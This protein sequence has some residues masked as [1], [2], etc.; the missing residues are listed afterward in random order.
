M[1]LPI[2]RRTLLRSAVG[3]GLV[4]LAGGLSACTA[5][6]TPAPGTPEVA[7]PAVDP[8]RQLAASARADA[9]RA[10]AVTDAPA[11]ARGALVAVAAERTQHATALDAEVARAAGTVGGTPV[12]APPTTT[13]AP[14]PGSLSQ[15]VAGLQASSAAASAA[16][17]TAASYR[18][19]L[20]GSVAASCAAQVTVL[21]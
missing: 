7:A 19:G 16:A 20:L 5:P 2:L 9:A 15:L 13:V 17:V 21:S 4:L 10:A 6:P 18:A 11:A 8:L 14:A 1:S 3:G 12:T